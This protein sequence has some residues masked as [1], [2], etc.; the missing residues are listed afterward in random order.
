MGRSKVTRETKFKIKALLA[1]GSG[2]RQIA[3]ELN[4]SQKRTFD[5]SQKLKIV[6]IENYEERSNKI[7][8]NVSNRM[9]PIE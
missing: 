6:F 1:S 2:Q 9:E 4:I 8:S 5:V 7:K 3:R